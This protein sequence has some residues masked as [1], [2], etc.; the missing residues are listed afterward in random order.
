MNVNIQKDDNGKIS[1]G[2][3][4]FYIWKETTTHKDLLNLMTEVGKEI[5]PREIFEL[6]AEILFQG[7]I[8]N[9]MLR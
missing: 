6:Y 8:F 4:V 1:V 7:Y 5:L 3:K 9:R 2:E